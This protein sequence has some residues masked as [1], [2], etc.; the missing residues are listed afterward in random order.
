VPIKIILAD[1]HQI[2]RQGLRMLLA[3]EPD[4]MVVGESDNG[5]D[6]VKQTQELAPDVIIM[7]LSMLDLNGIDATRQI[8]ATNSNYYPTR[9]GK[10]GKGKATR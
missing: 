1:D 6:T 10:R 9:C 7:D 8:V 2:V 5:R 4:M 3:S